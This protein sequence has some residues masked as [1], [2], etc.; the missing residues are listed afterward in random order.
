MDENWLDW[1][2]RLKERLF[3]VSV[4]CAWQG[5]YIIRWDFNECF[6]FHVAH[7][8]D[9]PLDGVRIRYQAF[10]RQIARHI[11]RL[12]SALET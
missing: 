1:S 5:V 9:L 8:K 12:S 11:Q 3:S 7:R 6:L 4:Q 10:E 2:N